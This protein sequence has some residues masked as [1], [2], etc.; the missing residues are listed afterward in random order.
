MSKLIG[1]ISKDYLR[2]A[3]I[4]LIST[5]VA[6]PLICA[7]IFV[8]LWIFNQSGDNIWILIVPAA[9]FLLILYGGAFGT[10]AWTFYR[11]KRWLDRVFTPLG[12]EGSA[13][14]MLSGRQY[15]GT[16]GGREV[17]ARFYR[18]P[19]LDLYLSTPLQTRVGIGEK[20]RVGT[21]VAGFFRHEPLSLED[22]DLDALS[23]FALDEDWARSLLADPKARTLIQQL[24]KA[25]D[26]W[27]LMQQVYLQ[28]G[29]FHL[30]LYRNKNLFRYS[31][32]PEEAQ[33]WL[34]GLMALARIA[35]GLPAPQV[36]D[37]ESG[38]ER[39]VRS[40]RIFPLALIIVLALVGIPTCLATGVAIALILIEAQ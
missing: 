17:T 10:I 8:P 3:V 35:E 32:E 5:F 36:T 2:G 34:G 37:E 16:V 39:L 13:Y 38:A 22:P 24:M 18:G 33:E 19:T 20:S 29:M 27:A 11:R 7:L 30:R 40:G 25:G 21:A 9:L 23:V 15:Q 14:M 6:L 28:P 1:A 4:G 31:I 12:L 26:S